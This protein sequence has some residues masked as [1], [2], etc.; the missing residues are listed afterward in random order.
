MLMA[1]VLYDRHPCQNILCINRDQI[2]VSN[3]KVT[4]FLIRVIEVFSRS[5]LVSPTAIPICTG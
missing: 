2:L 4:L 5:S 3:L 1:S